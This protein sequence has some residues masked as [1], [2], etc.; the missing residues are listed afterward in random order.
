[1]ITRAATVVAVL[2]LVSACGGEKSAD[3][4][5]DAPPPKTYTATQLEDA[6]PKLAEVADGV[7][8]MFRCPDP[9]NEACDSPKVEGTESFVSL[10]L[11]IASDDSAD[12]E[13]S[14][15]AG[16]GARLLESGTA[17][18]VAWDGE[19][20]KIVETEGE[21]KTKAVDNG[22]GNYTPGLVGSGSTEKVELDGWSGWMHKRRLAFIDL[23]GTTSDSK[24]QDARLLLKR[25]KVVLMFSASVPEE[26]EGASSAEQRASTLAAEYLKRLG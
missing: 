15:F 2:A 24:L 13:W 23:E 9:K 6:L 16:V 10:S 20:A 21:F 14:G 19:R 3:K 7:K 22:S 25:G 26:L 5:E 18:A 11:T 8:I 4:T 17:A 12:P 1:M